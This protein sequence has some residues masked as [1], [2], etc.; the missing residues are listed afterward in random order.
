[1]TESQEANARR[2]SSPPVLLRPAVSL[3]NR[4]RY[5]SKFLLLGLLYAIPLAVLLFWRGPWAWA[6]ALGALVFVAYLLAAFYSSVM[7]TVS[8]LENS[9]S[10]ML[11]G[12]QDDMVSL[13]TQDE[14][15]RVAKSFNAIAIGLRLEMVQAQEESARASEA[16]NRIK[17]LE[18]RTRMILQTAPDGVI[19]IDQA[20]TV[21]EWNPQ[22]ATIFGWSREETLGKRLSTLIV[23]AQHRE[24]H[25]KGLRRFAETGEGPVLNQR[26]EV[27]GLRRDGTEF[28]IELSITPIRAGNKVVFSAFIRDITRRKEV[29]ADLKAAKDAAETANQ[30]KSQ[31]LASM[32]HEL[33]TPLNSI[34]GFSGIL[35]KK[36]A[37]SFRPEE[38]SYLQRIFDNGNHLL[39]LINNILDLSKVEAGKMELNLAR[40]PLDRLIPDTLAQLEGRSAEQDVTLRVEIPPGLSTLETDPDK[41]RQILINLMG[42]ALKF[43]R[44]GSITVRVAPFDSGTVPAR[45]DVIDT[46]IGIPKEQ[47]GKIFEA[48]HQGEAGTARTYG[49]SGLG[50]AITE[51]LCR[52][53][54]FRLTVESKEGR[55]STFSIHLQAQGEGKPK[56]ARR[57]REWVPARN[58]V[59]ERD[60]DLAEKTVL[61]IDDEPDSRLLLGKFLSECGCQILMAESGEEGLRLARHQAVDLITLD[62]V[63]PKMNGWEIL[64]ELKRDEKTQSIP[65]VVVSI[66][67][68]ENRGTILGASEILIM[69]EH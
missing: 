30:A 47:L 45:I 6:F 16:E 64:R 2:D 40:V 66:V 67:G 8:I 62:L 56:D 28:P 13:E 37:D 11:G 63:M 17:E 43:T 60:P 52:L 49:G 22:A 57:M 5:P 33:R 65:V 31:F 35:L 9:T 26:I 7:R 39:G 69:E 36:K 12:D 3:L 53:L 15:G 46:G 50:L 44:R 51:S 42:N 58:A 21:M 18:E 32:S 41:L 55:G 14:L 38:Q 4:L 27:T 25:D 59:P 68:G 24:A 61:V 20:G 10:K 48:F 54:G 29:E 1:M 23:P 19:M 34:I